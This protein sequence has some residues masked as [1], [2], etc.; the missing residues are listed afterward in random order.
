MPSLEWEENVFLGLKALYKSIV[1]SPKERAI[2]IR[3][4]DL[5]DLKSMLILIAQMLSRKQ[6]SIF[7]TDDPLLYLGDRI[8]L[9]KRLHIGDNVE[10]NQEIYLLRSVV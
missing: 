10:A 4:A 3:Q 9:P 1:I 5:K 8:C 2:R 7:E 6:I